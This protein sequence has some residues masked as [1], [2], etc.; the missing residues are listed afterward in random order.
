MDYLGNVVPREGVRVDESK[1]AAIQ[2]WSP[3]SSVKQLRGFLGL[4]SYYHKFIKGFAML[5]APLTDLLK[6]D[7]F[8]WIEKTQQAFLTFK[9]ALTQAP[10]LALPDFKHPFV[11]EIDALSARI[12]A[13]LSQNSH[14]IAYFSKKLSNR[15]Q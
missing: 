15:M 5:A 3:P 14:P 7:T 13:T 11:L 2:H 9:I 1:I 6:K 8:Q 12:G 10:I 4:A